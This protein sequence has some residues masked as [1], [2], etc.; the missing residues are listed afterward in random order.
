MSY[1]AVTDSLFLLNQ[2]PDHRLY[3]LAEFNHY[4]VFPILHNKMVIHYEGER[5]VGLV[6]WC[7]LDSEQSQLFLDEQYN[8]EEVDYARSTG[9]QLWVI[10][11]IAPYGHAMRIFRDMISLSKSTYGSDVDI[12]WRRLS[13]PSRLHKRKV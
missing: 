4:A 11:F 8:P 5:P 9:E 12:H 3:T 6:T 13:Q 7:W 1:K 2:S 10:E